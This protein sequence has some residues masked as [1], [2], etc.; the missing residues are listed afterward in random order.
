MKTLT[1][2]RLA[3]LSLACVAA[4]AQAAP[5]P[6]TQNVNVVNP[7]LPVEVSNANPVPVRDAD[8]ADRQPFQATVD[9]AITYINTQKSVVTVPDGKRLI[10]DGISYWSY[11][12]SGHQVIFGTLRSGEFGP[13][14]VYL[15]INPPHASAT[16]SLVI[17]DGAQ[18][19]Q[20]SF[21]A[22]ETVW[23]SVSKSGGTSGQISV[24]LQGHWVTL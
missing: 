20:T 21:E 8:N 12:D 19:I 14:R 10:I 23:L 6:S 9:L 4:V 16:S 11:T 24:A 5:P 2:P 3:M 15:Q 22:G 1:F 7:V 17:Q 18:A 13:S